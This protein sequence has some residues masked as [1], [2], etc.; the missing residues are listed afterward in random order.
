MK[1]KVSYVTNSPLQIGSP[2]ITVDQSPYDYI[3][4][5]LVDL[6]ENKS[7]KVRLDKSNYFTYTGPKQWFGDWTVTLYNPFG[8]QIYTD[9]FDPKG[10]TVFIKID[11][12][13]LGD[14]LAWIDYVEQFRV[15]HECNVICSTFWN[16]LFIESYPKIMF[17]A[18]NTRIDNVYA[19]YY[20]GTHNSPTPIYQPSIYL[21]NPLQKIAADILGLTYKESIAKLKLPTHLPKKK[22]VTI[23]EYA[24]LR[25][26]E[27]NVVGG[28]Q[29][30]VNFFNSAGFDVLVISKEYSYLKNVVNK[31]GD[32][33]I[34]S[35]ISDIYQSQYHIGLSTGLS[36]IAP[37]CGTHTFLI[38]DFTPP[39][40]EIKSNV[41]RIYNEDSPRQSISYSEVTEPVTIEHVLGKILTQLK[42]DG[43]L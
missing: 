42:K 33:P 3:E 17:V 4:G 26:K 18:P 27:W 13:A 25:I 10:K 31:S 20:I 19:Q 5:D 29:A 12:K 34:Q 7:Y 23:S 22:Q 9:S 30:I 6:Y 2:T 16:E 35:R 43:H 15:K 1:V 11:A 21:Y 28:W 37:S 8:K 32:H 14:N 24:S 39:D 40:H 36:W 38:S 41:T